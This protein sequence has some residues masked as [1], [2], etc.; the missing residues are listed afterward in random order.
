MVDRRTVV[1]EGWIGD[2]VREKGFRFGT[3]QSRQHKERQRFPVPGPEDGCILII[4]LC[5]K[6]ILG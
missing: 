2:V 6:C 1:R 3:K 5:T 4:F